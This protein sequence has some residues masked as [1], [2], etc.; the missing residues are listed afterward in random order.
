MYR[1]RNNLLIGFHGCDE[2]VRND[3]V[4]GK[5]P[6]KPSTNSYDWLGNGMYFWENN[7]SRAYDWAVRSM[8]NPQNNMQIIKKP[9]VLGAVF[10]FRTLSGSSGLRLYH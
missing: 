5:I 10:F 8:E 6:F 3:I 2:S 4:A 9:A 1:T 7:L